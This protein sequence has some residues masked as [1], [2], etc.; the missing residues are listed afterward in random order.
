LD[1]GEEEDTPVVLRTRK[2]TRVARTNAKFSYR[3]RNRLTELSIGRIE[4]SNYPVRCPLL[5]FELTAAIE[6]RLQAWA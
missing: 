6:D 1:T 3:L 5:T 4:N 2:W